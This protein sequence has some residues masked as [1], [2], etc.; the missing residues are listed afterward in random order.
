MIRMQK[1]VGDTKRRHFIATACHSHFPHLVSRKCAAQF[2]N[3]VYGGDTA[4]LPIAD[5]CDYDRLFSQSLAGFQLLI[6]C[7]TVW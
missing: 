1:L 2:L 5:R 6:I 3:Q 7:M 4:Y